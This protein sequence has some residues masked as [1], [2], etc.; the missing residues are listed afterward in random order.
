[1]VC[2]GW[3]IPCLAPVAS[4]IDYVTVHKTWLYEVFLLRVMLHSFVFAFNRFQGPARVA[5][6]ACSVAGWS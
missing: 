1:M 2:A 4:G 6:S 3:V 5:T